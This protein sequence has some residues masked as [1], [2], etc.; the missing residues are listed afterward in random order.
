MKLSELIKP[1]ETKYV[2][3]D[4]PDL[5]LMHISNIDNCILVLGSNRSI[6]SNKNINTFFRK[7]KEI[8]KLEYDKYW[9]SKL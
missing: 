3:S 4:E 6:L 9:I 2:Q 1:G 5:L 8:S 7:Y